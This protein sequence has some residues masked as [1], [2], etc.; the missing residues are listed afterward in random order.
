MPVA[1]KAPKKKP[2]VK[3][4][5]FLRQSSKGISVHIH[6]ANGN[7]L[8]VMTGYNNLA[9]AKKGIGA[10]IR[11]LIGKEHGFTFTDERKKTKKSV[12]T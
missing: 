9:N 10:L 7:K 1:K 12:T 6:S 3:K 5:I 8:A 4:G 2:V 11:A